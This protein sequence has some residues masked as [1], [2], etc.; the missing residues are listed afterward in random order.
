MMSH[1]QLQQLGIA[2]T[3]AFSFLR[4][5]DQLALPADLNDA[6]KSDQM[7]FWRHR[8]CAVALVRAGRPG[9]CSFRALVKT[10]AVDEYRIVKGHIENL[11]PADQPK[12]LRTAVRDATNAACTRDPGCEY[13]RQS[14]VA[15]AEAGQQQG[16]FYAILKGKFSKSHGPSVKIEDLTERELQQLMFTIINR[17]NAKRGVGEAANRNKRSRQKP[18]VKKQEP[19]AKPGRTY[20]LHTGPSIRTMATS[21]P[22]PF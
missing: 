5:R 19:A 7:T 16:Y 3:K 12:A 6:T 4:Q 18:A 13:V 14:F 1:P 2:A 22:D 9:K 10:Q 17:M 20:T 15:L 11:I 8:E 21:I